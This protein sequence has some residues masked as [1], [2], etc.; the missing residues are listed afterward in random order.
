MQRNPDRNP[1]A[2]DGMA[3]RIDG[4]GW[5]YYDF[6]ARD[7]YEQ[8]FAAILDDLPESNNVFRETHILRGEPLGMELPVITID[9]ERITLPPEQRDPH[10]IQEMEIRL[11]RV[12]AQQLR[13]A[14][15]DSATLEELLTNMSQAIG[16]AIA[17]R[18]LFSFCYGV[19][20]YDRIAALRAVGKRVITR[21]P[22]GSRIHIPLHDSLPLSLSRRWPEGEPGEEADSNGS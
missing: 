10:A 19:P 12:E 7:S 22:D 15:F 1:E 16:E 18:V 21:S 9:P 2:G 4:S 8:I 14:I 17:A 20:Q 11:E 13:Q 6:G 5:T 3:G